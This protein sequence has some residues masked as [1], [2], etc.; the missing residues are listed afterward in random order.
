MCF[1]GSSLA[2]AGHIPLR[3][4]LCLFPYI[5]DWEMTATS[6][7]KDD[8]TFKD[9]ETQGIFNYCELLL[10]ALNTKKLRKLTNSIVIYTYILI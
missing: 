1:V 10:Y 5:R 9:L 2:S 3:S 8:H 6:S 7:D 4:S